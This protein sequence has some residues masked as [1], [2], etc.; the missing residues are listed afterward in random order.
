MMQKIR[1]GVYSSIVCYFNINTGKYEEYVYSLKD[2]WN[3]MV[4]LGSQTKLPI[5][6]RHYRNIL[7]G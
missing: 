3:D 7:P 6:Q 1:K 2:T 5:G 4:H